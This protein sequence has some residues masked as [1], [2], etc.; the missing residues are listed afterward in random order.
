ML[1]IQYACGALR[2]AHSAQTGRCPVADKHAVFQ[3]QSAINAILLGNYGH[4]CSET[5]EVGVSLGRAVTG[6]Y[7]V[8]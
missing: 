4:K 8:S 3:Y 6:R 2:Q 7:I 1:C 5:I